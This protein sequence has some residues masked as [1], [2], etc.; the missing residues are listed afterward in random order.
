MTEIETIQGWCGP[1]TRSRSDH[2]SPTL[3]R[4]PAQYLPH[5]DAACPS[6]PAGAWYLTAKALYCHCAARNYVSWAAGQG[7]VIACDDR[8]AAI[9]EMRAQD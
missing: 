1:I 9:A 4:V 8:E 7:H 2:R 6:C 5:T 3:S